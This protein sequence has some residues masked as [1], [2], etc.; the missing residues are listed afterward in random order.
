MFVDRGPSAGFATPRAASECPLRNAA[1]GRR[2]RRSKLVPRSQYPPHPLANAINPRPPRAY[3]TPSGW[4]PNQS[5]LSPSLPSRLSGMPVRSALTTS[6]QPQLP[7]NRFATAIMATATAFQPPV[8]A[9][10]AALEPPFSLPP[11][12]AEP[13]LGPPHPPY[14]TLFPTQA[15]KSLCTQ[16]RPTIKHGCKTHFESADAKS[17][18]PSGPAM[19]GQEPH[20][21]PK[22][23]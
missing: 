3:S 5:L 21:K 20:S 18:T 9:V 12:S 4:R 19:A 23:Q 8:N 2:G 1:T 6:A 17:T 22:P 11:L 7:T 10:A 16:Q 15:T 14:P 13:W